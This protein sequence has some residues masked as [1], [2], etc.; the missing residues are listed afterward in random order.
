MQEKRAT[1]QIHKYLTVDT[2]IETS[3]AT[4]H[5]CYSNTPGRPYLLLLHGMGIDA[6][7]NWYK[8][9]PTLSRHFNLLV[10]DLI[11]FGKSSAKT[12][13]YSVEFQVEQIREALKIL[14]ISDKINVMGFS[15][16]GLTAAVYNQLY[17]SE[18]QK[19]II[20]DGPVKF[21]SWQ[22]ADSLARVE[23][24][25]SMTNIIVPQ[26]LN[27]YAAM[28]KAV[29]SK[30]VPS[31]SKFKRKLI[32]YYFSPTLISRQEQLNYLNAHQNRYQE[33]TYNIETTPLLLIWGARDGVVP[34]TVGEKLHQASK[35]SSLVV[36]K[37]AKH[38]CHFRYARQLNK[39]V[40]MF[41]MN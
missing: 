20:I 38:D 7:T 14:S 39:A 9:I 8:Q 34:L 13:D 17:A 29:L 21:Y 15:Y 2:L 28:E 30:K 18:V 35:T 3:K 22:M 40:V 6:K 1:K 24:V 16:G 32:R 25:P 23:G 10:P 37:R 5:I 4:I 41:L 33:Y 26:N 12:T 19:L 36:F 31:T 27:D 11:Y